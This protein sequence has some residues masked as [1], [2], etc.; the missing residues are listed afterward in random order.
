[1][2][3]SVNPDAF[4]DEDNGTISADT[5]TACILPVPFT[6]PGGSERATFEVVVDAIGPGDVLAYK[7]GPAQF[8][9]SADGS[10]AT[11]TAQAVYVGPGSDATGGPALTVTVTGR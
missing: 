1:M 7:I 2:D 6:Y 9:L 4:C 5:T 8:Q 10:T 11:V 3:R